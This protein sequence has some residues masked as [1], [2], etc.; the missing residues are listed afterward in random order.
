MFKRLWYFLLRLVG[1]APV[2]EVRT[3]IG[4]IIRLEER[5]DTL[6]TELSEAK[7][8]NKSLWNMLEE[9][10]GSSKVGRQTVNEFVE[11]IKDTI[12]EEMLKDFDPVGEA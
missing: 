6:Q 10:Q 9:I 7:D 3:L 1:L 4:E 11:E 8:E 12:M 2:A 5:I